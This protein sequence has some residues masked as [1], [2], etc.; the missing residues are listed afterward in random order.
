MSNVALRGLL[1]LT[2]VAAIC[3]QC[4]AH[5]LNDE[6]LHEPW[7]MAASLGVLAVLGGLLGY[8]R[9]IRLDERRLDARALAEALRVRCW[10][11]MAGISSSTAES[12][13]HQLRGEMAWAQRALYNLSPP[14]PM[15]NYWFQKMSAPDRLDML[16]LV[17][18]RWIKKQAGFFRDRRERHR[19]WARNL[20]WTGI[21]AAAIGW[22]L[23]VYMI[24]HWRKPE[25]LRFD[26]SQAA[27]LAPSQQPLVQPSQQPNDYVLIASGTL[28]FIGGLVIAYRERQSHEE[29]AKQY[30]RMAVVFE[31]G[32]AEL[33]AAL[34]ETGPLPDGE[35]RAKDIL[36]QL[37]REALTEHAQWL[38]LRRSRPLEIQLG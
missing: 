10:W 33:D 25:P 20:R 1:I 4:Y 37:G 35:A 16:K 28:L 8:V 27:T 12:Y 7:Y 18:E 24:W 29:L 26:N 19:K 36:T 23:G 3:F 30:D 31:H 34:P 9:H 21:V 17:G 38:I 5:L 11:G 6:Y 15:W 14:P 22:S 13:L 2:L 32:K